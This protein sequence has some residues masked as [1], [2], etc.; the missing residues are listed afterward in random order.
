M[1]INHLGEF[2]VR[3]KPLPLQTGAPVLEES[4]RPGFT[5]VIPELTEG[6]LQQISRVQ[7]LVR[8]QQRLEGLP[9]FKGEILAVRKQRVFLTFDEAAV[10]CVF[11]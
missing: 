4:P 6:F 11:R 3:F 1:P 10:T 8:H 5:V 7:A 9:A 2:L